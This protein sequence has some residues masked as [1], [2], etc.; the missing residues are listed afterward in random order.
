MLEMVSSG[1]ADVAVGI[2]DN[3]DFIIKNKSEFKTLIQKAR[4]PVKKSIGYVMFSK[5]FYAKHKELVECFWT[6]S[7]A[8]KKT[9]WFKNMKLTYE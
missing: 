9:D 4:V 6:Q 8:L 2:E 3:F 1:R 5:I 7:A